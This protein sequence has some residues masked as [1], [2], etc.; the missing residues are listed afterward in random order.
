MKSS[1]VTKYKYD[2]STNNYFIDLQLHEPMDSVKFYFLDDNDDEQQDDE[3]YSNL[4]QMIF[5]RI[6][7]ILS[8]ELINDFIEIILNDFKKRNNNAHCDKNKEIK[9]VLSTDWISKYQVRI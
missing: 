9:N 8:N 6:M 5:V 2:M 4:F 3:E 7:E 1:C